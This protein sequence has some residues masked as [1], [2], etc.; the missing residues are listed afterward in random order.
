M[1]AGGPEVA[2]SGWSPTRSAGGMRVCFRGDGMCVR[3]VWRMRGANECEMPHGLATNLCSQQRKRTPAAC[4]CSKVPT[5]CKAGGVS[6][7][8]AGV[9]SRACRHTASHQPGAA[10][11]VPLQAPASSC[12]AQARPFWMH[13][14]CCEGPHRADDGGKPTGTLT[15]AA[16]TVADSSGRCVDRAGRVIRSALCH[17]LT[18]AARPVRRAAARLD[19]TAEARPLAVRVLCRPA[20]APGSHAAQ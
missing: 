10:W 14:G 17:V 2:M 6:V 15:L 3:A 20:H 12:A 13:L 8:A 7:P 9:R 11:S 4:L 18:D 16:H 19:L 1:F 5:A